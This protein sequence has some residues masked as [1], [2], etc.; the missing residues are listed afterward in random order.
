MLE[1]CTNPAAPFYEI[2][3]AILAALEGAGIDLPCTTVHMIGSGIIAAFCG[4]T[5]LG[6][7]VAAIKL[8]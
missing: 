3:S 7:A 2:D 6:F 5:V 4:A 8:R 1:K